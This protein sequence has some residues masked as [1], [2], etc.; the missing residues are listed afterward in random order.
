MKYCLSANQDNITLKKAD[1]IK[2]NSKDWQYLPVLMK[3]FPNKD[4]II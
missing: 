1:E 3:N 2:L 4:V